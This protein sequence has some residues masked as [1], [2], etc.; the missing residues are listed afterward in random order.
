M[1][2]EGSGPVKFGAIVANP[3][4]QVSDGGAQ[5]S[6]RAI[7]PHFVDAALALDPEFMTFVIPSRWYTGGKQLG[8]FRDQMLSDSHIKELHDYP[9][10]DEVFPDTNNRGGVCFFLRDNNY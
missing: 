10:P 8:D 2:D 1:F 9:R 3:P 5:A 6:A 4:Y 7:Y